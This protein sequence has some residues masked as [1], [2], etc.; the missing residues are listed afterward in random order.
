[1]WGKGILHE[2]KPVLFRIIP[3]DVGKSDP[4]KADGC[5]CADHPHGCGEKLPRLFFSK[6]ID[7]SSPRMWGKV[8]RVENIGAS[9]RIIPTDVGKSAVA[10]V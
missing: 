5:R 2:I 3:T 6:T 4:G 1:M 10:A 8:D 7:G 9:M